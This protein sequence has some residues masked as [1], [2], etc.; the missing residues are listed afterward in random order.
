MHRPTLGESVI[1]QILNHTYIN[2]SVTTGW[3]LVSGASIVVTILNTFNG[4][5]KLLYYKAIKGINLDDIPVD[6]AIAQIIESDETQD[7]D[8][9]VF[10]LHDDD[11]KDGNDNGAFVYEPLFKTEK[12]VYVKFKNG[13]CQCDE[14][15]TGCLY[16]R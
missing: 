8:E 7:K 5:W 14:L 6:F 16:K 4:L 11:N 1:I 13:K 2:K 3:D 12:D 10:E 9:F 15:Y